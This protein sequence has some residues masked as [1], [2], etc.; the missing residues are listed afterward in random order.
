MDMSAVSGGDAVLACSAPEG[1]GSTPTNGSR[2]PRAAYE[3]SDDCLE[4]FRANGHTSSEMCPCT[5]G[6]DHEGGHAQRVAPHIIT[7]CALAKL[8]LAHLGL[9]D[10][11]SDDASWE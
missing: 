4:N 6:L 7:R 11:V 5:A 1:S 3:G 2:R 10:P 9:L 8:G